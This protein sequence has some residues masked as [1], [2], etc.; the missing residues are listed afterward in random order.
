M[1][2]ELKNKK[3]LI[4]GAS[5]GIG[6]ALSEVFIKANC[7]IIFTSSNEIKLENLKKVFGKNH[8]YYFL[9][10]SNADSLTENIQKISD[11]NK[12]I[13]ILINNAGTTKD[14]LILRMKKDQWEDVINI[15]L[16]SNFHIIK[17]IIPNMIKNK[18]GKIIGITSIVAFTGNPGQTNYTASKSGMIAMYKSLALEVALRNI[19]INLIAPGFIESPMTSK[20]NENQRSD[21][22]DKIPMKRFGSPND[23]ANLALFLASENAS[24]ITGQTFHVNGGMLML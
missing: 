7:Q 2:F 6:K 12:D 15:N 16:N 17:S 13:E 1:N 19:N 5:G 20:L 14:N 10:L 21:I 9:D 11:E 24:Y 22:M 8:L 23:V 18:R 3:I 4:T